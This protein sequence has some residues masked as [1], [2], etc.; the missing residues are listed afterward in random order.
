M[1]DGIYQDWVHQNPEDHLDGGILEDSKCQERW[2]KLVCMPNQRY[3]APSGK[4]RKRFLVILSVELG[5]VYVRKWNAERVIVF[6]S[7]ILQRAQGV[8]NSAQFIKRILF[9][10]NFW[11]RGAF[12]KLA[13]YTYNSA[14]GY[15]GKYTGN[16]T[17]EQR[18][19]TFL[20]LVLKGNLHKTI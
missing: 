12:D 16:Q 9:R 4:V 7:V 3:D 10:L 2:A 17:E 11:N 18:H 19:R 14:M 1:I 5:G 8:N 20:K 15:L 13:K 6:K